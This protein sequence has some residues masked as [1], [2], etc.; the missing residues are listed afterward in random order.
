MSVTLSLQ[1]VTYWY[2]F[3]VHSY[4]FYA[5]AYAGYDSARSR[6]VIGHVT[7]RLPMGHFL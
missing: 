7:I 4:I 1:E 6:D 5:Y 2:S 3:S